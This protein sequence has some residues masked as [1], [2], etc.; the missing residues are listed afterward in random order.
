VVTVQLFFIQLLHGHT[1][2]TPLRHLAKV[3]VTASAYGQAR[4]KLPLTVF[5]ELL[6][7]VSHAWPHAPLE[8]G[9]WLGHR[10]FWGDGSRFS[11]PDPPALHEHVGQPGRQ[12]P[13]CGFPVA[14]VMTLLH[15]GTGMVL[16]VCAAPLRTH[17][18]SQ[19]VA[20][21]PAWHPTDVLVGDRGFC[22]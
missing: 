8:E 6:R 12:L 9:R 19:V 13:G 11:R 2:C 14:H 18:M 10:T 7:S 16:R 20:L 17:A 15:A 4:R 1:A 5:Q 3:A 22:S 21:H